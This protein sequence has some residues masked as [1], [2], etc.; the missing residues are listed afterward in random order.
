MIKSTEYLASVFLEITSF[1][2]S[3]MMAPKPCT[4]V[5]A[6]RGIVEYKGHGSIMFLLSQIIFLSKM[7]TI[8]VR[9]LDDEFRKNQHRLLEH[10]PA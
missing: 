4:C 9:K 5:N 6:A 7:A 3:F 2:G 8:P 1:L 10:A